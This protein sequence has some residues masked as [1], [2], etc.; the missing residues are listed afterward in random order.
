[1]FKTLFGVHFSQTFHHNLFQCNF[2][3]QAVEYLEKIL[4]IELGHHLLVG[5]SLSLLVCYKEHTHTEARV[6][7][8]VAYSTTP[9]SWLT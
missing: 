3:F 7:E 5:A 8:E 4:Y 6:L 1:M 9:L 2:N